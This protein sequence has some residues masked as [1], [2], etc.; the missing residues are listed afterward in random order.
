[1]KLVSFFVFCFVFKDE[2]VTV[3]DQVR[4]LKDEGEIDYI[5]KLAEEGIVED[6]PGKFGLKF[7]LDSVDDV[8]A[9]AKFLRQPETTCQPEDRVGSLSPQDE[10]V[11][12]SQV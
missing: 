4:H 12:Q 1:M 6:I 10:L 5:R 8:R 7:P 11:S 3:K 9:F 2:L